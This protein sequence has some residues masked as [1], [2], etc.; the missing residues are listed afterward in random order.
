MLQ[1]EK[2]LHV[3]V[4][5]R[6]PGCTCVYVYVCLLE[7]M[8]RNSG[9]RG[10]AG[11][12]PSPKPGTRGRGRSLESAVAMHAMEPGWVAGQ[13]GEGDRNCV[14]H[15]LQKAPFKRDGA[16]ELLEHSQ[17]SAFAAWLLLPAPWAWASCLTSLSLSFPTC[18]MGR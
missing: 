7:G 16:E 18:K 6:V 2:T 4:C 17:G 5:A 3:C 10:P 11:A 15:S 13:L 1:M 9:S 12:P 8:S 14:P